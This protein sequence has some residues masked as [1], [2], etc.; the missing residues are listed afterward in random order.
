M[1]PDCDCV[2]AAPNDHSDLGVG[3]FLPGNEA[4][5]L[6]VSF[7][8]RRKRGQDE[9][10]AV[11]RYLGWI[12]GSCRLTGGNKSI[13]EIIMSTVFSPPISKLVSGNG[14]QPGPGGR[15]LWH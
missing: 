1:Y 14:E 11:G 15:V 4:E 12:S 8:Q 2:L 13:F 3:Q 5:D 6:L 9:G 10:G 7:A